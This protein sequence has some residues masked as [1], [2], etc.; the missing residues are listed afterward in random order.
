MAEGRMG[1]L[2]M[3][4]KFTKEFNTCNT[5]PSLCQSAC[6]VFLNDANRTHSPWGLMQVMNQVRSH[7]MDFSPE[8]AALAYQC[9][10]CR[11]CTSQC[12]HGVDVAATMTEVREVAVK[13]GV[14][15]AE[16]AGYVEKFHRHNNPF[17]KDLLPRL[18]E[19]LPKK[20]FKSGAPIAY[21]ATCTTIAKTPDVIRDTFDLFDK[22]KIDFVAAYDDPI[23]CCGYPLF[24]S[25]ALQEF[26]DLAEINFHSLQKHKLIVTGS[27]TCAYTLKNIYARY[28]FNLDSQVVTINEFLKPYLKNIN[29]KIK[30]KLRTKLMYHDPCYQ[31]RYLNESG[32]V[33]EMI[34]KTTGTAPME[35]FNHEEHTTCSGQGGCYNIV[36]NERADEITKSRLSEAYEKNVGTVVT[37]CPT[38]L[39][40]MQNNGKNLNVKDLISYI[41][42]CIEGVDE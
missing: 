1:V 2:F 16:I 17:S 33:R 18:K 11:G 39:F 30:P 25:G 7:A 14:A 24:A 22:L 21:F 9:T 4:N 3:F 10:S 12:E 26:I 5:C 28:D 20:R 35:F 31:S 27:P 41:N 38:C 40:K 6:P 34:A 36:E 8:V 37:Q 13:L 23:Q 29:Y 42:D 32:L 15:P 19:I